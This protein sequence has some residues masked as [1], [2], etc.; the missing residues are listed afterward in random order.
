MGVFPY[1]RRY[2]L[3]N[4]AAS[5]KPPIIPKIKKRMLSSNSQTGIWDVPSRKKTI[6]GAVTGI[7]VNIVP[8][9]W[10]A[11]SLRRNV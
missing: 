11:L 9:I 10:S 5:H 8:I 2:I 4:F 3:N 1:I 6:I 7:K